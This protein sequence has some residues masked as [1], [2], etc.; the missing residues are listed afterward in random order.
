[1]VRL[2][3]LDRVCDFCPCTRTASPQSLCFE[4]HWSYAGCKSFGPMLRWGQGPATINQSHLEWKSQSRSDCTCKFALRF[5]GS[6]KEKRTQAKFF[7][8]LSGRPLFLGQPQDDTSEFSSFSV[9]VS[10]K[11]SSNIL[12]NC[13]FRRKS[14]FSPTPAKPAC[15]CLVNWNNLLKSA[16]GSFGLFDF[17]I[18]PRASEQQRP[19]NGLAWHVR[20]GKCGLC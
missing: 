7:F 10:N 5:T 14:R 9:E 11:S 15:F 20:G 6:E 1:M 2:A 3:F 4:F 19:G 17:S 12:Q 13:D 16:T 8:A 18:K